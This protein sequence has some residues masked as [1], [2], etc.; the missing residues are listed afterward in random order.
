VFIVVAV[1][2]IVFGVLGKVSA[3]FI[4]IPYPVLGGSLIIMMGM[5]IGVVLSLLVTVDLT[6]TRNLAIIGTSIIMGLVVPLWIKN[7][8]NDISTGKFNQ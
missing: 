8:P 3:V 4:T 6:S 2:Y 5:V 7:Y 1:I